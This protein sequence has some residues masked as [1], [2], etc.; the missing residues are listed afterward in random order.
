MDKNTSYLNS[1]D[2]NQER[3]FAV[4]TSSLL[5][6]QTK[7]HVTRGKYTLHD[8]EYRRLNYENQYVA[9]ELPI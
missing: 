6:S 5:S 4:L 7:E 8:I 2:Y 1:R 3:R 9:N